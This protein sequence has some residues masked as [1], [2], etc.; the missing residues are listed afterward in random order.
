[1]R[2]KTFFAAIL[3]E[4]SHSDVESA[5]K[6][7]HEITKRPFSELFGNRERFL[8]RGLTSELAEVPASLNFD[9]KKFDSKKRTYDGRNINTVLKEIY[10][11]LVYKN[12]KDL[13]ND[14]ISSYP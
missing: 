8:V 2:F 7:M 6:N 4:A 14:I 10:N 11:N 9:L 5:T 3:N 13:I 1:M 12:T